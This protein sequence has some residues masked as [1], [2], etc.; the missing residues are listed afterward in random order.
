MLLNHYFCFVLVAV[1][2]V[3]V[4]SLH[5]GP[6]KATR[7]QQSFLWAKL[8]N[9]R[10]GDGIDV[11]ESG[12]GTLIRFY[13]LKNGTCPYAARTWITLLELGLPFEIIELSLE[14]RDDW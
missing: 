2:T 7:I 13:N 4:T 10:A 5:F 9:L 1:V 8:L 11:Q 3:S 6:S 14:D 12:E